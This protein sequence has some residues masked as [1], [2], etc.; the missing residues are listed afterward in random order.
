MN[1]PDYL[2][3]AVYAQVDDYKALVLTTGA[4]HDSDQYTDKIILE[5]EVIRALE[6]YIEQQRKIG[7][8]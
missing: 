8:L 1:N 7:M 2:G 4:H 3:D 5:P 6:N